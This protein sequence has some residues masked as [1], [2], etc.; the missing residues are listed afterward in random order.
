MLLTW[1]FLSLS[2]FH[3]SAQFPDDPKIE[4]TGKLLTIRV[5]P[6]DKSARIYLAG[7]EAAAIDLKTS[8]P[9]V[10]ITAQKGK[11]RRKLEFTNLGDAYE[12][13]ELPSWSKPYELIFKARVKEKTE[14]I[15]V[16]IP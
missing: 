1:L 5:V 2:A 6:Q 4:A 14:D 12:V 11:E 3:L 15:R 9:M 13:K 8:S 7:V 16:N 10:E